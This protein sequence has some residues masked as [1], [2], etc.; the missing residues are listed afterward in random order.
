MPR[1]RRSSSA[2]AESVVIKKSVAIPNN[3]FA[4][5]ATFKE[6]KSIKQVSY[7]DDVQ[8]DT[9]RQAALTEPAAKALQDQDATE[10]TYDQ[11][12]VSGLQRQNHLRWS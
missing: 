3:N 12:V 2:W 9:D 11:N 1:R 6:Q 10:E 4:Y 7:A 5:G 8:G